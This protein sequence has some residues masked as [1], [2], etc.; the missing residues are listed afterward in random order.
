MVEGGGEGGGETEEGRGRKRGERGMKRDTR[1]GEGTGKKWSIGAWNVRTMNEKGKLENVKREMRRYGMNVL[2]LS[3][4]RWKGQGDFVSDGTRVMYSGGNIGQRGVAVLLDKETA[5]M[6]EDVDYI[7][8]R[9]LVVRLRT[10]PVNTVLVQ[11]YMP[12]SNSE[13]EDVELMYARL[14]VVLRK[15]GGKENVIV[16]G[17]FNASVGEG[18]DGKEVG[19]FGLG[20]RNDRGERL[21][22]FCKEEDMIVANTMFRHEKRRRYTWKDPGDVRRYQ[23]D[24]FLVRQRYRNSVKDARSYPG[25]DANSDHSLIGMKTRVTFKEIRGAK[26]RKKWDLDKL[27]ISGEF[28]EK[29]QET[30]KSS[31]G[32]EIEEK[33]GRIKETIVSCARKCIGYKKRQRAKKKWITDEVLDKMDERRRW[34][35]V[36]TEDGRKKYK[37]VHKELR[38]V[39]DKA[40]ERWWEEQCQD[41]EE[42]DKKGRNDL[43]YDRVRQLTSERK[44]NP[45]NSKHIKNGTGEMVKDDKE[46]RETWRK[47]ME[48][49][50]DKKGKPKMEN[51]ETI[52]ETEVEEDKKGPGLL[53]SEIIKAIQEM[54]EGKAAGIDEIPAEL[55]KKMGKKGEEEMIGLC[56][57]MYNEGIWPED[58]TRSIVVPIPKVNNASIC[59]DYRTISLIC[60]ASKIML[61]ILTRRIEYRAKEF[62]GRSQ[63]GFRK[64]VGTRDAIGVV[65]MLCERN[66]EYRGE[67]YVCFVDFEKAFDRVNWVM[68]MEILRDLEVD[69]KDRR[70]I[71][72]L[73]MRQTAVVRVEGEDSLPAEIGRGVR[74][75]CPLSPL[76]FSIYA[77]AMMKEAMEGM[78]EGIKVGGN[79]I[80]DVRFADDQAMVSGTEEGLQTMMNRLEEIAKKY[81][82]KIN[83]KKTKVMV[84][85][86][87]AGKKI[88][89]TIDGKMIEQV[90]KFKYLGSII[91]E[92]G[93]SKTDIKVRIAMAKEA[94]NK[95]K[96]LL[97]KRM[98]KKIRK[99]IVKCVVWPVA[100]YGC[101]TWELRQ[102]DRDKLNAFEMWCWRRMEKISYEQ[103]M[104]NEQV[105]SMVGEERTLLDGV[106]RRKKNWIGH[107]VRG[108]GL[109]KEVIEGRCLGKR[110]RGRPRIGM[111]EELGEGS[112]GKMK[113]RAEDREGWR[114]WKPGTGL[115]CLNT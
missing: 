85:S 93:K 113:R 70:L 49:L 18:K 89:I 36:N 22:E 81:D 68:M 86:K 97:A 12:T 98:N 96:E 26:R 38:E 4:V 58:F 73:Y 39:T 111:L 8:D 83:V 75:G 54:R 35:S 13:E 87:E 67:V 60:H 52:Q 10:E 51:L 30:I 47:Y 21:V 19:D 57:R 28:G 44:K 77:E 76:L 102:T 103:R 88:N 62:I 92:D 91:T 3:E 107:V 7:S 46:A 59:S 69:W 9:M 34:K 99:K 72:Q 43:V 94:F 95:R 50:Y 63:F 14:E 55:I 33:W 112:Y 65:R 25:A 24:Y 56:K 5:G 45:D 80:N 29:V 104:T 16:M 31:E 2:G 48:D 105:L 11:V 109:M 23:I 114:L 61:K 100:L 20:K 74:Q 42:M 6:V 66:I 71:R 1:K 78:E 82:M 17:D 41:I 79:I 32:E 37:E 106:I 84:V 53:D 108:D 64:G 40:R 15:Q 27:K 90:D 101:E 110:G 115:K